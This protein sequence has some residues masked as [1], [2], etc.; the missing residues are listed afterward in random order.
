MPEASATY[1]DQPR[2]HERHEEDVTRLLVL[3][4]NVD[5]VRPRGK[6]HDE[7]QHA[8]QDRRPEPRPRPAVFYKVRS[9]VSDRSIQETPGN[10]HALLCRPFRSA[11]VN[12]ESATISPRRTS[13]PPHTSDCTTTAP[14]STLPLRRT[15]EACTRAAGCSTA[16]ASAMANRLPQP[17]AYGSASA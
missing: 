13:T 15:T 10:A 16:P 12:T 1:P 3:H 2:H 14:A 4:R 11:R 7:P 8:K 9:H 17:S 6:R 5:D